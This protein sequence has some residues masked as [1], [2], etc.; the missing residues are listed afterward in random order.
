M[1]CL[2][3]SRILTTINPLA[4]TLA[5]IRCGRA[6]RWTGYC[7]ELRISLRCTAEPRPN[8]SKEPN[9][10]H[11][12]VG[13]AAEA[14]AAAT[15]GTAASSSMSAFV[16]AQVSLERVAVSASLD[17]SVETV[18]CIPCFRR[19][20]HLRLTLDSLAAQRTE[21]VSYTHL[22]AHET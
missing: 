18:I 8:M 5:P 7:N 9:S 16:T 22:R 13:S 20:Q 21:P 10:R 11:D 3:A 6:H 14:E 17:V 19:P 12:F 4:L 2:A 1:L 15:F